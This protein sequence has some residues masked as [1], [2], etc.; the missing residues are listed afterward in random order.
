[1]GGYKFTRTYPEQQLTKENP[2]VKIYITQVIALLAAASTALAFLP[3]GWAHIASGSIIA[4]IGTYH[5][6]PTLSRLL[7]PPAPPA[8]KP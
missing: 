3:Y 8:P 1:V 4:A 5:A 7:P 2:S 6:T